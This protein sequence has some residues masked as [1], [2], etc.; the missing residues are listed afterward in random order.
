MG[1]HVSFL[2][3][4]KVQKNWA[5]SKGICSA[6]W[7][8]QFCL[9]VIAFLKLKVSSNKCFYQGLQA[10][11]NRAYESQWMKTFIGLDCSIMLT[12]A[13]LVWPGKYTD[14]L[15][16]CLFVFA[17]LRSHTLYTYLALVWRQNKH[18]E[19]VNYQIGLQILPLIVSHLLSLLPGSTLSASLD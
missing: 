10:L 1:R 3:P 7:K 14:C 16:W 4:I 9:F 6:R 8:K 15:N 11:N 17:L 18:L 12:A 5:R 2:L 19:L 13:C